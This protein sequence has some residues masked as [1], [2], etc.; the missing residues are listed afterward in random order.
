MTFLLL[1]IIKLNDMKAILFLFLS[2]VL[3]DEFTY[4]IPSVNP[5]AANCDGMKCKD[6][7]WCIY[8]KND[9]EPA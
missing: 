3:S 8:F 7:E 1:K 2:N 5:L 6:D 4:G 9:Q